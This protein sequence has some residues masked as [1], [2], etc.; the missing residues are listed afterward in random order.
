[1]PIS[2]IDGVTAEHWADVQD[3]F[4][5]SVQ[6]IEEYDCVVSLVSDADDVGVI[7]KRI[8]QN[9]YNSDVIIC[10]V[11]GKNPNV[12]F[13]LGMRLA[14]D[15]P[16]VIV[17]D[18]RTDYSFDTGVIEHI[19]YPRDLRFAK[20][21]IFKRKLAVKVVATYKAALNDPEHST[22]L[23]NFGRFKVV[24]LSEDEVPAERFLIDTMM[25][26]Q[27]QVKSINNS[28]YVR[29]GVR[30]R[31]NAESHTNFEALP[32]GIRDYVEE[33][34]TEYVVNSKMT[35]FGQM[36]ENIDAAIDY[37]ERKTGENLINVYFASRNDFR[38]YVM[39]Q[40]DTPFSSQV[41]KNQLVNKISAK[42]RLS[43]QSQR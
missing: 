37:V 39:S 35:S 40:L 4:R 27:R 22:F 2:A 8:V 24:K 25:D 19:P 10:D 7:Q 30:F 36:L 18:D 41:T 43:P 14:F 33:C 31:A 20:I 38:E 3:I 26:L 32:A 12:M 9:I 1:M 29:Q 23:K 21:V 5:E 16:T 17:K 28:L 34:L 15:K 11:S 6:T 42:R 13:E